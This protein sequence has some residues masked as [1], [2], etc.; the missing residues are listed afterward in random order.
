MASKDFCFEDRV[1]FKDFVGEAV[2]DWVAFDDSGVLVG[3][4]IDEPG[5]GVSPGKV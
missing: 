3:E 2:E 1:A 5:G 4:A